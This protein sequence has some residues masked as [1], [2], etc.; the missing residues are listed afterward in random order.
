MSSGT[1]EYQP[2]NKLH[3][4]V[5]EDTTLYHFLDAI[6]KQLDILSGAVGIAQ[7]QFQVNEA[8][9]TS[10]DDLGLLFGVMRED[11]ITDTAF[12]TTLTGKI[13]D[14]ETQTKQVIED[15]VEYITGYPDSVDE[16]PDIDFVADYGLTSN[17]AIR[18]RLPTNLNELYAVDVFQQSNRLIAAGIAIVI[19]SLEEWFESFTDVVTAEDMLLFAGTSFFD[20]TISDWPVFYGEGWDSAAWDSGLWD[21][22][23]ETT[24]DWFEYFWSWTMSDTL[25]T[26]TDAIL[27]YG[28]SVLTE[29]L[30]TLVS[31]MNVVDTA[32]TETITTFA[33]VMFGELEGFFTE[34]LLSSVLDDIMLGELE[35]I[36]TDDLLSSALV[37]VMSGELEGLLTDSIS[38]PT[39]VIIASWDREFTETLENAT[40]AR[41]GIAKIGIDVIAP[42]VINKFY[43]SDWDNAE[44]DN[45]EWDMLL[46]TVFVFIMEVF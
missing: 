1:V 38:V 23:L 33:D 14:I 45:T 32:W 37:S 36:F 40:Y 18:I 26:P 24:S 25:S 44:W 34:T 30:T 27:S 46:D 31:E 43:L 28:E 6:E 12:R 5:A 11:G 16:Y 41:I 29:L 35:G 9:G 20:E 13:A 21:A 15:M 7:D 10:L 39:D 3:L 17:A 19:D 22:S 42:G 8:L 2:I 4:Q